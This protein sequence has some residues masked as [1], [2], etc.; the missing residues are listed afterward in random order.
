MIPFL[1]KK[2]SPQQFWDNKKTYLQKIESFQAPLKE[3]G[4]F[5]N[6]FY[7]DDFG[8][9]FPGP[10]YLLEVKTAP[11]FTSSHVMRVGQDGHLEL[12]KQITI[13]KAGD[14]YYLTLQFLKVIDQYEIT[15]GGAE[16]TT[17]TKTFHAPVIKAIEFYNAS[18]PTMQFPKVFSIVS[19]SSI[20]T[21]PY[22]AAS[23]VEVKN[24]RHIIVPVA[25]DSKDPLAEVVTPYVDKA[26]VAHKL[27][28]AEDAPHTSGA[29]HP[30]PAP[31]EDAYVPLA[32]EL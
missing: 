27:D 5:Y 9:P 28:E 14:K 1:V 23:T 17:P 7:A 20:S 6:K 26:L 31:H 15:P 13:G 16:V 12:P 8:Y 11:E 18:N 32:G 4:E 21:L 24:E 29:T 25:K 3:A 2:I 10:Y 22:E 19:T 30:T